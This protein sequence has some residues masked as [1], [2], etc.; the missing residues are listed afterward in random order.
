MTAFVD[1]VGNGRGNV[2]QR[3][4]RQV[5][6]DRAASLGDDGRWRTEGKDP[7]II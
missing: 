4:D 5:V 2:V 6:S 7:K 3:G 1:V